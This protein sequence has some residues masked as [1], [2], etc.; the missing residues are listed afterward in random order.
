M[1]LYSDEEMLER[2]KDYQPIP[3]HLEQQVLHQN[4]RDDRINILNG[5]IKS[6][7]KTGQPV[8]NVMM[9]ATQ[10]PFNIP[11]NPDDFFKAYNDL[12]KKELEKKDKRVEDELLERFSADEPKTVEVA[13]DESV[14]D[15]LLE[16]LSDKPRAI[17]EKKI[18]DDKDVRRRRLEDQL[19]EKQTISQRVRRFN[20]KQSKNEDT[21]L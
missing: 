7:Y 6:P 12:V 1:K 5:V 14:S 2:C 20:E 4:E 16:A 13:R 9:Y 3:L 10:L 11:I 19:L 21:E 15:E 18:P 8:A 17:K